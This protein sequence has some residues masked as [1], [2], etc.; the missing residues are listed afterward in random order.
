MDGK[1]RALGSGGSQWS[2]E[3]AFALEL[4]IQKDLKKDSGLPDRK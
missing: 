2:K 1:R 3:F 4:F